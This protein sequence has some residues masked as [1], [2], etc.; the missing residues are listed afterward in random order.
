M[1]RRK[2]KWERNAELGRGRRDSQQCDQE[3]PEGPL[4]HLEVITIITPHLQIK[5]L[6]LTER[7]NLLKDPQPVRA[8]VG[9]EPR[10]P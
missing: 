7:M 5:E 10:P 2:V 3:R 1:T 8:H 6:R 9:F 4:H